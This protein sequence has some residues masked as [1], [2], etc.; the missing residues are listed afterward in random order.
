ML[1]SRFSSGSVTFSP[2]SRRAQ[3]HWPFSISRGPSSRRT[4]TPFISHSANFQPGELSEKSP[5]TR[6]PAALRRATTASAASVTPG[7]WAAIGRT[8]TCMGATRG[9]RTRP[10]LSP[11]GHDKAADDARGHAPAGLVGGAELVLLIREG[12]AEGLREAVAEIVA[13]AG[14]E[15]LA[16]VHHALDGVGV[17]GPG[18]LLL[19]G[20]GRRAARAWRAG[21]RRCRRI[22]RASARSPLWP[23]RPWRVSCGPPARGIRGP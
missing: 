10:L 1:S 6:T 19:I 18:E 11:W 12:D 9:G 5:F 4:G 3:T 21:S 17:L 2:L 8:I 13:R 20:L 23:P 14:L 22:S 15:G 16:V 7:L